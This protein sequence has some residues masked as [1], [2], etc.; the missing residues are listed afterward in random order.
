MNKTTQQQVFLDGEGDAWF[1]RNFLKS[2]EQV[3]HWKPREPLG[4][5]LADLMPAASQSVDLLIYSF[6]LYLCDRSDLFQ[7]AAEAYRVLNPS[8]WLAIVDFG[9]PHERSNHYYHKPGVYNH[10]GDMPAMF[11]WHPSCVVVDH[12]LHHHANRSYTD[13][14]NEWVVATIL[15]RS[16]GDSQQAH[17]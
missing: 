17:G 4:D 6:C 7:I 2:S 8:C 12:R 5:L 16:D 3:E 11:D 15:R 10:K 9:S 14:P 13:D 1:K